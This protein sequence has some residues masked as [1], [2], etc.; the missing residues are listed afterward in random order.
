MCDTPPDGMLCV[1]AGNF[2]MGH[3]LFEEDAPVRQVCMPTY[4]IDKTEVTIAEYSDCVKMGGCPQH[5]ASGLCNGVGP[6]FDENPVNCVRWTEARDYCEWAGKRLPTEAEWEKAA[7]GSAGRTYPWGEEPPSCELAQI[8]DSELLEGCGAGRTQPV[9]SKSPAG[10]SPFGLQDMAGSVS[11]WCA[12]QYADGYDASDLDN[13]QGPT[14]GDF[15]AVRGGAWNVANLDDLR[16]HRRHPALEDDW[17][18]STGF[19]CA[20]TLE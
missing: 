12:D 19:R 11:E 14:E 1:P 9:G 17:A 10:D 20:L 7:R 16:T 8:Y 4:Y 6:E 3:E 15:R 5:P 13:P 18:A 2:E